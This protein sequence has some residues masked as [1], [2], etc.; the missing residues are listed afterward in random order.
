M[1]RRGGSGRG[2]VSVDAGATIGI[3]VCFVGVE[4]K[5]FGKQRHRRH[6][7]AN[8]LRTRHLGN[9]QIRHGR[10]CEA[11]RC[12]GRN[13]V[14]REGGVA[15]GCH[16]RRIRQETQR[17]RF[18]RRTL[19][20]S[21][22]I[23]HGGEKGS[24]ERRIGSRRQYRRQIVRVGGGTAS[25]RRSIRGEIGG[26]IVWRQHRGAGMIGGRH[27]LKRIR[28]RRIHG[29]RVGI[30]TACTSI[31]VACIVI[32]RRLHRQ[33]VWRGG[34]RIRVHIEWRWHVWHIKRRRI[35]L[36]QWVAHLRIVVVAVEWHANHVRIA[37][38]GV[39]TIECGCSCRV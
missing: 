28:S 32:T 26:C 11:W 6:T 19:H 21:G 5:T 14:W 16:S 37:V 23:G 9:G 27:K 29:T 13:A 12:N 10:H 7:R 18:G 17:R 20:P 4:R 39:R 34:R 30:G 2:R 38:I 3:G 24:V 8:R 35:E 22:D 31:V 15:H 1:Y 25:A 36:V 33:R